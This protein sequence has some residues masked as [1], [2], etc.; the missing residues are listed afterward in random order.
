[1]KKTI[2]NYFIL[3]I[4]LLL[5]GQLSFAQTHKRN[6]I[7]KNHTDGYKMYRIPTIIRSGNSLLAFCEG[8]QSLFDHGHI[9]LVMKTSSDNGKT[10]SPLKLL[11]SDGKNTCGNPAPVID[12]RTGYIL[13]VWTL[14]NQRVMLMRSSDTGSTWTNPLDITANIK[15]DDWQ[16]YATGPVHGIQLHNAQWQNR[17]IITCNHT[18]KGAGKH[19]SHIIYSDDSGSSWHLGGV[20]PCVY[21]DECTVAELKDGRLML[22]MRN[23]D[24]S[25]PDRK[26][27][28][29][30]DGGLHWSD[31]AF[32]STLIEPVC[33]GSLLPYCHDPKLLLFSNPDH[34]KKRKNLSLSVSN[35]EGKTWRKKI[36]LQH[37]PSAYSDMTELPDGTVVCIYETGS[38][39]PYGGIAITH[40]DAEKITK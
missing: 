35:D 40:I 13:L 38:F 1:M 5:C 27:C 11:W 9:D 3:V 6:Y 24:R 10:W 33:Q 23:E 28:Y 29:S 16:W 30:T 36:L 32:D 2:S 4:T 19:I 34:I 20:V 37:G 7:F 12:A 14:N 31:C 25:I 18:L 15:P 26:V 8:R 21:S 17:I 39:W 22:N